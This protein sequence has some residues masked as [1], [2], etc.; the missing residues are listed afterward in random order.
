MN[1][2]INNK[3]NIFLV[4]FTILILFFNS[5]YS[6]FG[7]GHQAFAGM[8]LLAAA[9][10]INQIF[11]LTPFD[12]FF[13]YSNYELYNHHPQLFFLIF[14]SIARFFSDLK[15]YLV[16]SRILCSLFWISGYLINLSF[17]LK[18][19]F[20]KGKLK[21]FFSVLAAS[22]SLFS[23]NSLTNFNLTTFDSFS[24]LISSLIIFS[25]VSMPNKN[26]LFSIAIFLASITSFYG[27]L[28]SLIILLF[29]YLKNNLS[30]KEI[31]IS[32]IALPL[33]IA[34]F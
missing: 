24:Y 17:L 14:G 10:N 22:S 3:I 6:D 23:L 12:Y 15:N 2:F 27:I 4:F 20:Q 30:K 5:I 13:D 19:N 11:T 33:F 28:F 25:I 31:S 8:H 7:H 32:F 9:R 34:S 1:D 21:I 26:R 18:I 16:A 29:Y